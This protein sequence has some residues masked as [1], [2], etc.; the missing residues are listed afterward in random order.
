MEIL[1]NPNVNNENDWQEQ[2]WMN[3]QYGIHLFLQQLCFLSGA[4][5]AHLRILSRSKKFYVMVDSIG[6]YKNIGWKKR[7]RLIDEKP[8]KDVFFQIL[9]HGTLEDCNKLENKYIDKSEYLDYLQSLQYGFWIPLQIRDT[10][11]GYIVLSWTDKLP[12]KNIVSQMKSFFSTISPLMDRIYSAARSTI[13]NNNLELL[14]EA[15]KLIISSKDF[16]DAYSCLSDACIKIWGNDATVYIGKINE[17]ASIEVV[18]IKGKRA[19]EAQKNKIS[20]TIPKGDGIFGFAINQSAVVISDCLEKENRFSYYSLRHNGKCNGSAICANILND[21]ESPPIAVISI[22]HELT[23]YFDEDDVRCLTSLVHLGYQAITSFEENSKKISRQ[24]DILQTTVAHDFAEPLSGLIAEANV[25]H[26]YSTNLSKAKTNS[27]SND[28]FQ[29][30]A[31]RSSSIMDSALLLNTIVVKNLEEGEEGSLTRRIETKINLFRFINIVLDNYVEKARNQ[32]LD[33]RRMFNSLERIE[34][35]CDEIEF[36]SVLDHL[37][38]NAIKYSFSGRVQTNQNSS[39]F[40][41]YVIIR[42]RVVDNFANIEI[43]NYGIGI[44]KSELELVKTKFYR[45][46]LALKEGKAGTGRGL[47]SVDKFMTKNNGYLK[48]HSEVVGYLRTEESR[49]YKTTIEIGLPISLDEEE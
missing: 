40:S 44:L 17:D 45:G 34:V 10:E 19:R 13:T 39:L 15:E 38:N 29:E 8:Q 47:W 28:L 4:N 32:G 22:E 23:N 6:P 49:P 2:L 33:F 12:D 11:L 25:L 20:K 26:Y 14:W 24:L 37:I 5:F 7:F 18:S 46:K 35:E 41:R 42:G 1:S 48:I 30:I 16:S 43:E 36:R 3:P 9:E 27:I 21:P 31:D